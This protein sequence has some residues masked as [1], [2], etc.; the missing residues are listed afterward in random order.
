MPSVATSGVNEWP[1][2]ATR[3]LRP[4]RAAECTRAT[5]SASLAGTAS[6]AGWQLTRPDQ[7]DHSGTGRSEQMFDR[8]IKR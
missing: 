7:L 5:T 8:S 6:E 1:L 3:T 4:S 2:P